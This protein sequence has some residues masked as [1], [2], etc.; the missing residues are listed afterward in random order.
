MCKE[1]KIS[2]IIPAYNAASSLRRCLDSIVCC[3]F[4]DFEVIL[5]DDGS[6]DDTPE[7]C[8]EYSQADRRIRVFHKHNG[9]V[10]SARNVGLENAR[11]EWIS[12]V[13]ADDEFSDGALHF[14]LKAISEQDVDS[15]DLIVEN[16]RFYYNGQG[17]FVL[18]SSAVDSLDMLYKNECWG[19]VWNKLFSSRV[20]KGHKIR[21][22]E[23]LSLS[24]DCLFVA[25]YCGYVQKIHCIDEVCYIQN[26]PES[27]TAKYSRFNVFENNLILYE[28]IKRVNQ[29][30]SVNLVDGL[31]M[32]LLQK[33]GQSDKNTSH[34]IADFKSTVGV[35]I[36]FAKG[37]KK[38]LIRFLSHI[39]S[40][41][42]WIIV[43]KF[44]ARLPI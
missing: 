41:A 40:L 10:S 29:A 7:I 42:I 11:G 21:F 12:F 14:L 31:T 30:C 2:V 18:F 43:F 3:R 1:L 15:P 5:V 23:S 34:P 35:D 9:G 38:I 32:S 4:D 13:D 19:A 17:G 20:I 33:L 22:D 6:T 16:V 36:K 26:L 24:E 25:E 44:H 27:Y 8:D 28:K 39:D 37:R